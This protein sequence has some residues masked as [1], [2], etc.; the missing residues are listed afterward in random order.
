MANCEICGSP[1]LETEP[2]YAVPGRKCPRCGEFRFNALAGLRA[3]LAWFS[4]G[5]RDQIVRLSGWVREQNAAGYVPTLT[6]DEVTRIIAI[7]P[8]DLKTRAMIALREISQIKNV[9]N[10][11]VILLSNKMAADPALLGATYCYSKEDFDVLLRILELHNFITDA[12]AGYA[13]S[14]E[15]I[16]A[17]EKMAASGGEFA[18][19]FVAMW[20]DPQLNAAWTNGFDPA[21]RAAGYRPFRIDQKHYVGGIT[22]E[23][24]SEIRRSR[25][26][27]TDYTEQVNGVYFEAGFALGLGLTVIP[28]CREDQIAKLHFDIRHLNTLPWKQPEDLASNLSKRIV[29]ILGAGPFIEQRR[30]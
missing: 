16:L 10:R 13:L 30:D 14:V 22:D 20:F 2:D 4:D 15:G 11:G 25:F 8:P 28:T 19:G 21:I 3:D 6:D 17:A 27:V 24:I 5:Q 26:V 23:I 18:Q 1:L 7:P 9:T 29:A 12:G